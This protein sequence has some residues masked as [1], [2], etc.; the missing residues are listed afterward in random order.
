MTLFLSIDF[1]EPCGT[2]AAG[3]AHRD[4]RVFH[5]APAALDKDV[6][7]EAR[8]GHTERMTDGNCA[9]VHVKTLGR[10]L[11][12]PLAIDRLRCERFVELPQAN[13]VHR[14]PMTREQ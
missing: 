4:D 11:E 13:V 6:S 14:E 10:N 8:A 1:E 9:A 12:T 3:H 5:A 7:H 2:H